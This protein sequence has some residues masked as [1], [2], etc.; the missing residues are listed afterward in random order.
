[1]P[2]RK[3]I[4]KIEEQDFHISG[5]VHLTRAA[6]WTNPDQGRCIIASL[7]QGVY[8][9]EYDR[10]RVLQ[11][12]RHRHGAQAL[13][14]PWWESIHFRLFRVLEDVDGSIIGAIYEYEHEHPPSPQNPDVPRYVIAFRGIIRKRRIIL[15]DLTSGL[16]WVLNELQRRSSRFHCAMHEVQQRVAVAGAQNVWLAGH[17]LGA[18]IAMVVGKNMVIKKNCLLKTYLFNPPFVG[19]PIDSLIN[20]E[21]LKQGIRFASTGVKAILINAVALAGYIDYFRK[22]EEMK[23]SGAE[24]ER[25][26]EKSSIVSLFS[27]AVFGGDLEASHLLPSAHV[28]TNTGSTPDVEQAH[29]IDQWWDR[30]LIS[31]SML[32]QYHPH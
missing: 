27:S 4:K 26:A 12:K 3:K 28:T 21:K 25:I 29:G 11:G 17:S 15:K 8:C 23:Q 19:I 31:E 18:A 9:L 30:F 13:A 6:A 24:T 16:G 1:M 20:D 10:L 14:P 2:S 7:V 22:R 5:P 32:Y